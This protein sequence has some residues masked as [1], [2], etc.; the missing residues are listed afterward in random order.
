MSNYAAAGTFR[1]PPVSRRSGRHTRTSGLASRFFVAATTVGPALACS[2]HH[3]DRRLAW[4]WLR[5]CQTRFVVRQRALT[6]MWPSKH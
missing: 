2:M 6:V 4:I 1:L 3:Y 5:F